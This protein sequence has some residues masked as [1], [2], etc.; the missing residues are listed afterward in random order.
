MWSC[1]GHGGVKE[2]PRVCHEAKPRRM[3]VEIGVLDLRA[4]LSERGSL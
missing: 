1:C 2:G 4:S 3:T